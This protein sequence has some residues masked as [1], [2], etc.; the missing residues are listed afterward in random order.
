MAPFEPLWSI[1]QA[2]AYLKVP[3]ETLRTWRKHRTG[4]A[5][6]KVGRHLRFDPARVRA[7]FTG[8]TDAE[9]G[10]D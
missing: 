3:V 1:D 2:A 4:P 9:A 10:D 5:A 6:A 8:L 7:W